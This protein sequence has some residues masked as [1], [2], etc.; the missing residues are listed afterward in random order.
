MGKTQSY[1]QAVNDID[2][3]IYKE[4]ETLGLVGESGCGKTTL[5]KNHPSA[6]ISRPKGEMVYEF[7]NGPRNLE[8]LTSKE[9]DEARKKI[10]IVFQDPQSSLNP[11]FTIYQSL[12]D[13]AEEIRHQDERGEKED[14]RRSAG[15]RKYAAGIHGPLS[16]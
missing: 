15:S 2:L 11:S 12:S 3:T 6:S 7:E 9:M 10:Q 16:P 8:K 13:P 5:G 14:H 1:V 4:G